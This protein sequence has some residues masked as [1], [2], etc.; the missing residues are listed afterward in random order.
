[1]VSG[2]RR[3]NW[4]A[5]VDAHITLS[6]IHLTNRQATE[7]VAQLLQA[8][9]GLRDMVPAAALNLIKGRLAELR[10]ELGANAFDGHYSM[11]IRLQSG[12]APIS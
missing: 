1:M 11:A 12:E 4:F 8:V 2:A 7:A 10:N 6:A 5:V 3:G 9:V